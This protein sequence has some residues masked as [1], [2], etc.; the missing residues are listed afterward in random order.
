MLLFW[1]FEP[2][3]LQIFLTY[4]MSIVVLEATALLPKLELKLIYDQQS[5]G[6]S[7]L[8]S[9]AHL[10]PSTN[11]FFSLKFPGRVC[12]LLYNWF[13]AL[14]ERSLLGRSPTELTAIFYCLIWDSPNLEGQVPVS[15][16]PRTGCPS[17][18]PGH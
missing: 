15:V 13:W 3:K 8:V 10:G 16:S 1:N 6:Q 7:V 18:T 17:Y 5:V 12:N 14:Q 4:N 11:F 9:G 2:A